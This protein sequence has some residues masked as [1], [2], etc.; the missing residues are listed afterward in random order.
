MQTIENRCPLNTYFIKTVPKIL[1]LAPLFPA[2]TAPLRT[3][4]I[5]LSPLPFLLHFNYCNFEVIIVFSRGGYS[6][7]KERGTSL[8]KQRVKRKGQPTRG[9]RLSPSLGQALT[10]PSF[11]RHSRSGFSGALSHLICRSA[12]ISACWTAADR[13]EREAPEVRLLSCPALIRGHASTGA[14]DLSPPHLLQHAPFLPPSLSFSPGE[15]FS[16]AHTHNVISPPNP[17]SRPPSQ[18]DSWAVVCTALLKLSPP[19]PFG[20]QLLL[21]WPPVTSRLLDSQPSLAG[22][23]KGI[24]H[25]HSLSSP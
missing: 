4:S 25:H 5:S 13:K 20:L 22:S 9:P 8:L 7:C 23:A 11:V 3:K 14:L 21:S 12:E 17:V 16:A 15:L 24:H 10:P 2:Q 18:Q 6:L 19:V 1:P